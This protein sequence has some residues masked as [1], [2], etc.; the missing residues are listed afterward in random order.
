MAYWAVSRIRS[1]ETFSYFINIPF[2]LGLAS[3]NETDYELPGTTV[4]GGNPQRSGYDDL[5]EVPW[6]GS[7]DALL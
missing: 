7:N 3:F 1:R 6:K 5:L 2:A 4:E